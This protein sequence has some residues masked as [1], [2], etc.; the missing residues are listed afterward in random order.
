MNQNEAR[1]GLKL[2]LDV[3]Q[4]RDYDIAPLEPVIDEPTMFKGDGIVFNRWSEDLGGFK[5]IIHK[6]AWTERTRF[7]RCIATFNHK[8]EHLL[9]KYK[10]GTLRFNVG[11]EAVHVEIDK[12]ETPISRSCEI[13]VRNREID[14]MSFTFFVKDSELL[15]NVQEDIYEHHVYEFKEITDF[16]LVVRQSYSGTNVALSRGFDI[17]A[18]KKLLEAN[19]QRSEEDIKQAEAD[20]LML[21]RIL[22]K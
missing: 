10:A 18:F 3:P 5:E 19:K 21:D 2:N 14:G 11:E 8:E 17:D 12:S 7:D 4:K 9:G 16:S 1:I 22:N 13:W 6:G 15:Y 20:R